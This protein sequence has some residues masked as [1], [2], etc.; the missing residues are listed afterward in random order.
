MYRFSPWEDIRDEFDCDPF[1]SVIRVLH[2]MNLGNNSMWY[3]NAMDSRS[4]VFHGCVWK[5]EKQAVSCWY[6]LDC[7]WYSLWSVDQY[8]KRGES[9]T[10]S[11]ACHSAS[12]RYFGA[13]FFP[14]GFSAHPISHTLDLCPFASVLVHSF[15]YFVC[16]SYL[17]HHVLCVGFPSLMIFFCLFKILGWFA[18]EYSW[19]PSTRFW[20]IFLYFTE[21][22]PFRSCT[23]FD[24]ASN[25][26]VYYSGISIKS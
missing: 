14:S 7:V 19:R 6:R 12:H 4:H 5:C 22:F 3:F 20:C 9:Y 1:F 26:L 2:R 24:T 16:V 18:D 15:H 21:N 25:S 13:C 8:V 10:S 17:I 23:A 11:F